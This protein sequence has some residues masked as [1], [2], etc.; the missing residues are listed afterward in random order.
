MKILNNCTKLNMGLIGLATSA[1]ML[2]SPQSSKAQNTVNTQPKCDTFERTTEITP[3]GTDNKSILFNAPSAEIEIQGEPRT[4]K[5]VVD[6]STNV[7]YKYDEFGN[8]EKA[9]L[10]ASGKKRTPT[11]AGIRVV[12]H[13]ESYPYKSAPAS[14]KRRREPWL[15]GPKIIILDKLNPETG[16]KSQTGEFI[17][18]NNNP[19]SIGKYAS[20]G[21]MRM[22][23]EVIKELSTEVKRGDIVII[24][25]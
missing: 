9:Y 10:I 5:I 1:I 20:L 23:N 15:Y 2:V 19:D 24:K 16:E 18:G 17:H 12:S 22:D 25:K 11:H 13:T 4:A 8:A 21:C 14:T 7:L 6:L 3:E